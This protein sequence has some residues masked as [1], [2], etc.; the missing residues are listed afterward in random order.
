MDPITFGTV[1]IAK[2]DHPFI[3]P[4]YETHAAKL[5]T[6]PLLQNLLYFT[7]NE[8]DLINDETLELLEPYLNFCSKDKPPK[9]LFSPEMAKN[10][11]AALWGLCNWVHA[12][13]EYRKLSK[14]AEP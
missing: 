10:T 7:A 3:L 8:K 14:G 6:G 2:A 13:S 11:S 4:S 12:I 9:Q 1:F 5:L